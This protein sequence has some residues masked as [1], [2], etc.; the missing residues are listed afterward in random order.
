MRP[1]LTAAVAVLA[2]AALAGC[3]N[4]AAEPTAG[5]SSPTDSPT[6]ASTSPST[7]E[8][9]EATDTASP[10][11][12]ATTAAP[13]VTALVYYLVD[14][15]RG[16][17]IAREPHELPAEDTAAAALAAMVAGPDDP[18]YAT[19]WDPDTS[20]LGVSRQGDVVTVDLSEDARSSNAGPDAARRMVQ[21]LVYTVTEVTGPTDKVLVT[22]EG[23]QPGRLWGG[24]RWTKPVGRE[25]PMVVRNL[26]QID[27]PA[28]GGTSG[29]RLTVTGEA[30]TFEATVPWRVIDAT[31][32]VVRKGFTT[33]EEGMTLS[34]YTF[35][36]RLEPGTYTVE[37]SE[38]DA[39]GG[40]GGV[41]PRTDNRTVTVG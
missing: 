25:D 35:T 30:A 3:G 11:D 13:P 31:G 15:P 21:Q 12:E 8:P 19:T 37:V 16:I 10:T 41:P 33:A 14:D 4:D 29:R 38:D 17:R 20:V 34:P 27:Y 6:E 24:V 5:E 9:T 23:Q 7:P 2:L 39:S 36:V 26:V 18:D 22:V 28:E 40:E 32:A 1:H